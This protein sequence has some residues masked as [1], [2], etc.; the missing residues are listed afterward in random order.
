VDGFWPGAPD[1]AVEVDSP[2]DSFS[3]VEAKSL[4]WLAAGARV[5]WVVDPRQEH[6]TVYRSR[7]DIVVLDRESALAAPDLL[8]GW[9]VRVGE[10]FD[11]D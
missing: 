6:V 10:I 8:P 5:V 7:E 4:A 11:R 9:Q 1:L 3:A 2:D